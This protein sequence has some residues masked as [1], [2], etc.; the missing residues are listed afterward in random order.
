MILVT[1]RHEDQP[2]YHRSKSELNITCQ[3]PCTETSSFSGLIA[4]SGLN[5]SGWITL[6]TW[7]SIKSVSCPASLHPWC[8]DFWY[9]ASFSASQPLVPSISSHS[10]LVTC[11]IERFDTASALWNTKKWALPRPLWCLLKGLQKPM[12][13]T[14][15]TRAS[16]QESGTQTRNH[17]PYSTVLN[18]IR[19]VM[20]CFNTAGPGST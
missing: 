11:L 1:C 20:S 7:G 19:S 16:L 17:T 18:F 8:F 14:N 4:V 15:V 12:A 9:S 6:M 5:M 13:V 3:W 2:W 10:G